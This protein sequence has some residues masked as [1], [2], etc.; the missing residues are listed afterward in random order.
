MKHQTMKTLELIN[1]ISTLCEHK[2]SI[3]PVVI[4][5]GLLCFAL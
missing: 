4:V 5:I 2:K 1:L 3:F